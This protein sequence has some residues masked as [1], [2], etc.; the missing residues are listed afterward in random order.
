M[1]AEDNS[2]LEGEERQDMRG[3]DELAQHFSHDNMEEAPAPPPLSAAMRG[4][5]RFLPPFFT[6][7]AEKGV[8][9]SMEGLTGNFLVEGFYRNGPMKVQVTES[10]DIKAIDKNGKEVIV[11]NYDEL[12]RLNFRWWVRSSSRNTY[13]SPNRPWIND[14]IKAGLVERKVIFVPIQEDE[15][16][17][18]DNEE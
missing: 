16:D 12:M 17:A 9:F 4:A 3:L 14:Y 13:V 6:E 7:L 10:D 15:S 1:T 5:L 18:G 2:P 8:S 11:H